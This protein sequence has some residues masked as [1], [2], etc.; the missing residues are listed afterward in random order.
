MKDHV[1]EMDVLRG[2]AIL[3]VI[4]I[5]VTGDFGKIT[6]GAGHEILRQTLIF[7]QM[8]LRFAVPLFLV[9]SGFVLSRTYFE[10]FSALEFY[11][12]R[13]RVILWPYAIFTL[14]YLVTYGLLKG[15]PSP[16][17]I[18]YRVLTGES[19]EH[20]WFFRLIVELY[21]L[22]PLIIVACRRF[23]VR[24]VTAALLAQTTL[25]IAFI[26]GLPTSFD[27]PLTFVR[28]GF[29]FVLGMQLGPRYG[30]YKPLLA[31]AMNIPWLIVL[32][33]LGLLDFTARGTIFIPF[34]EPPAFLV[35]MI[36]CYA[37]AVKLLDPAL[38]AGAARPFVALGRYSYGIFLIHV[39]FLGILVRLMKSIGVDQDAWV[40][41]PV[42]F[43]VTTIISYA[44]CRLIEQTPLS[45]TMIG[46]RR[47][48]PGGHN[49]KNFRS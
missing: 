30:L 10:Q 4:A 5:H 24:L 11:R 17:T 13:L 15:W 28:F 6:A 2:M 48:A 38:N 36:L 20:L 1:K 29:Y 32:V 31:G 12:K 19:S 22:Y 7:C 27:P 23:G 9:I 47:R 14:I 39:L 37:A 18:F 34:L 33:T 40:F 43:L 26:L 45:E 44:A 3:A 16:G 8:T 46:L 25:N 42:L 49:P 21:L 41:Y 35:T